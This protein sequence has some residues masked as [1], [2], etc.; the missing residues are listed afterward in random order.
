MVRTGRNL[1][2]AAI[3]VGLLGFGIAAATPV[4]VLTYHNDLARTGQNLFETVLT[5]AT[6]S[7]STF[8]RVFT[9]IVDG[10]VYA[11]PLIVTGL[12]IPGKGTFDVVF[13][14]TENDTVYAFDASGAVT[15]ALR[16]K[17]PSVAIASR[18]PGGACSISFH[19]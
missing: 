5:P 19:K 7:P 3:A 9:R 13:V 8:G 10:F 12:D 18:A 17:W 16:T 1:L 2:A 11:Q 14:A 6:V 4:D 15:R